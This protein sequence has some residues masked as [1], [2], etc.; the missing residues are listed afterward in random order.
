M[1]HQS[2]ELKEGKE[3]SRSD[4]DQTGKKK[5]VR[6]PRKSNVAMPESEANGIEVIEVHE[7]HEEAPENGQ[8]LSG[9]EEGPRK[10]MENEEK[11]QKLSAAEADKR[12][13]GGRGRV[14]G[15]P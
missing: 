10:K 5:R 6:K 8:D 2:P 7:E 12:L 14:K 13:F 1:I 15:E 11:P 4:G 9:G 3:D